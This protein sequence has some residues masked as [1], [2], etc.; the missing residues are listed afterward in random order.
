MVPLKRFGENSLVNFPGTQFQTKD[1][2]MMVLIKSSILGKLWT[3]NPLK[4][5]SAYEREIR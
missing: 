3:R 2:S 4:K 1:A 5:S